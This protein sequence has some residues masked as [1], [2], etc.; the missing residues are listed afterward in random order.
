MQKKVE[1][2]TYILLFW[3]GVRFINQFL[4]FY[5]QHVS[6]HTEAKLLV[7]FLCNTNEGHKLNGA[8]VDCNHARAILSSRSFAITYAAEHAVRAIFMDA[9]NGATHEINKAAKLLALVCTVVLT[10]ILTVEFV[11]AKIYQFHHRHRLYGESFLQSTRRTT[12]LPISQ[13]QRRPAVTWQDES[14]EDD[15]NKFD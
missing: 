3:I 11:H 14:E 4:F 6:L 1:N 2:L 12:A 13:G 8:L 15:K 9:W 5:A 7:R 10:F